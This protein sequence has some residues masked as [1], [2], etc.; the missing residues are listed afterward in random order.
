MAR[1]SGR[2]ELEDLYKNMPWPKVK[3]VTE[4]MLCDDRGYLWV[5]TNEAKEENGRK[6]TA[7]AVFDA[8][9]RYDTRVWLDFNP[10]RFAA[11]KMYRYKE[12][13]DTGVRVLT[14]Y[15]VVWE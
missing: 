6:R 5:A 2:R 8:D 10:A 15:R 1:T 7:Y 3:T 12:D 4:R 9:G 11:G 13:P 14:R